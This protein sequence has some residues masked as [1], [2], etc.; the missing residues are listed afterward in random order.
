[1]Q[2][3]RIGTALREARVQ[4]GKSLDEASRE[5][6]IRPEYL[7]ALEQERF[8][9]LLGDVYVRG[10]LRSYASYLGLDPDDLMIRYG[11]G[12][13]RPPASG[14]ER[15]SPAGSTRLARAASSSGRG[16]PVPAIRVTSGH[17]PAAEARAASGRRRHPS[18]T[19]LVGLAL[20]TL[21]AFAA[22][23]LLSRGQP[24]PAEEA[25]AAH[26]SLLA[27]PPTVTLTLTSRGKVDA[28]VRADGGVALDRSLR[29][30]DRLSFAATA[31]IEV[32]LSQGGLVE[33][34]VNGRSIGAP[35][36]PHSPYS[37]S[38]GPD[39]FREERSGGSG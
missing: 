8:D 7:G 12:S 38:F 14:S 27:G 2:S 36:D 19:V 9:A 35:G 34:T 28:H 1:M 13:T 29:P 15:P 24:T 3:S 16:A 26:P 23:R 18:S 17:R 30:G 22:A 10:F 21:I 31:S 33:L 11:G 6:R 25:A 20:V 39:A 5:T 4:R 32:S 37:A